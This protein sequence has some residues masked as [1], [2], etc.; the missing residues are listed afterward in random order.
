[1]NSMMN[2]PRIFLW[3]LLIMAGWLNYEAWTRDYAPQVDAA[4]A[5]QTPGTQ[6]PDL[7][8]SIPNAGT[9]ST[10]SAPG[11]ASTAPVPAPVPGSA[12]G[13]TPATADVPAT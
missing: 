11:A 8:A 1:M 10:P 13:T 9:A 5:Q 4:T 7:G 12:A 6:A 2:N 3:I